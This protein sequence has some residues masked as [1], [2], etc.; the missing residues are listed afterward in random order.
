MTVAT[1]Q[2]LPR[3]QWL[4]LTPRTYIRWPITLD[5]HKKLLNDFQALED[6]GEAL[7]CVQ[8]L[9]T[10]FETVWRCRCDGSNPSDWL[11]RPVRAGLTTYGELNALAFSDMELMN[12]MLDRQEAGQP[13]AAQQRNIAPEFDQNLADPVVRMV[14]QL[15]ETAQLP[16][17]KN[18]STNISQTTETARLLIAEL[19]AES[20]G[21]KYKKDSSYLRGK[22]GRAVHDLEQR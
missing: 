21:R 17:R 9:N 22:V 6:F 20:G 12:A 15:H 10:L 7:K 2:Q 3:P 5:E 19:P 4:R 11:L 1:I 18:G 13:K 16:K 14:R 8:A